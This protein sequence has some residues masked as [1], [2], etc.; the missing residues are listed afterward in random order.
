MPKGV[1]DRS[2]RTYK[3]HSDE[4]K[5]K[6]SEKRRQYY[7]RMTLEEKST[8]TK[9]WCEAGAKA[10]KDRIVS[11]ETREKLALIQT[12]RKKSKQE[13]EKISKSSKGRVPWNKGKPWSEKIKNKI[14]I[15]TAKAMELKDW[16][17]E[18]SKIELKVK[19]QLDKYN[20]K[21]HFQKPVNKGHFILDFYLPDYKLVIECNGDYWH[22]LENRKVRDEKLEE[23]IVNK[24]KEILWLWEHKINE[25]DF[26]L[27][28]Y[29]E[30]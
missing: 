26:D 11:K 15:N 30:I 2:Q 6:M 12:G 29:I 22:S 28:N 19:D 8:R 21:Y 14:R 9:S 13:L 25:E 27:L 24:G 18:P 5:A 20:I 1:Y 3:K 7:E 17:K 10:A 16:S 23:F 4:T